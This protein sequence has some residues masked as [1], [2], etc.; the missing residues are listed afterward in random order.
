MNRD[1]FRHCGR[2]YVG[3]GWS[4][5]CRNSDWLFHGGCQMYFRLVGLRSMLLL[6]MGNGNRRVSHL[7][8]W[9]SNMRWLLIPLGYVAFSTPL[10]L[11]DEPSRPLK[12]AI[13]WTGR[14][15]SVEQEKFVRCMSDYEFSEVWNKHRAND[16]SRLSFCPKV[17]FASQMIL[18]VFAG[19]DRGAHGISVESVIDETNCLRFRY[20][21]VTVQTG[22]SG[23]ND[24]PPPPPPPAKGY[25]FAVVPRTTKTVVF[26][27]GSRRVL[28]E[29]L[30]FKERIKLPLSQNR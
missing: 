3:I 12:P 18:G 19:R 16:D 23:P 14:D 30:Q 2:D 24:V 26:E 7:A 10:Y 27:Q 28:T 20:W 6:A 25:V 8:L 17:N 21:E 15:S 22:V 4:H 11:A 29:P 9:R 1:R 5:Q 13:V